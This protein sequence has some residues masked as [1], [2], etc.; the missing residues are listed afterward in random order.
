MSYIAITRW[1]ESRQLVP[2]PFRNSRVMRKNT[3][4]PNGIASQDT[5]RICRNVVNTSLERWWRGFGPNRGP[6]DPGS[7]GETPDFPDSEP[8]RVH[9]CETPQNGRRAPCTGFEAAAGTT[10]ALRALF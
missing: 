2:V 5:E 3:G 7:D 8:L 6:G 9:H 1:Y 10:W 4:T